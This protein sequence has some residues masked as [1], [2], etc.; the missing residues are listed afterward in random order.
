M[1]FCPDCCKIIIRAK[2]FL[3]HL[4]YVQNY[5]DAKFPGFTC[6]FSN[7]DISI[8]SWGGLIRHTKSH[9]PSE[10]TLNGLNINSSQV[11]LIIEQTESDESEIS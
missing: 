6:P 1:F 3:S 2:E 10:G 8:Y 9:E 7:C 11:S 5:G 4:K